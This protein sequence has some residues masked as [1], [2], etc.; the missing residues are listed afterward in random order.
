MWRSTAFHKKPTLA[1]L[2]MMS[3][4]VPL[5]PRSQYV[6]HFALCCSLVNLASSW[7]SINRAS[8]ICRAMAS[9]DE[10]VIRRRVAMS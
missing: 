3:S 10:P 5:E 6:S 4:C 9:G 1:L 7:T 2:D 8:S